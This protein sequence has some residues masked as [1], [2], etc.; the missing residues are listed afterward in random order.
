MESNKRVR[1]GRNGHDNK[2]LMIQL[3]LEPNFTHVKT[4]ITGLGHKPVSAAPRVDNSIG[5]TPFRETIHEG[6]R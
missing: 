2:F 6:N 5:M 3:A 4:I 1:K